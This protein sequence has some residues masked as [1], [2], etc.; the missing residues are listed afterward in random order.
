MTAPLSV[1]IAD[2][3]KTF[4]KRWPMKWIDGW[5]PIILDRSVLPH[6][7][8]LV[9]KRNGEFCV[10]F[11]FEP[12]LIAEVCYHGYMPMGETFRAKPLLLI[13]SHEHRCLLNLPQ[14]HI[15]RKLK[16]YARGLTF[17]INRNFSECLN[18][19]AAHHDQSWLIEPLRAAF[20]HLHYHPI[21]GVAFHSIEIYDG[22]HLVAGE[23]GY[24]TG[25]VYSSLS[26]FHSQNG[27]GSVQLALLGKV[28]ADSQF[29]FWDLGMEIPYKT[30]LGAEVSDR[31]TFLGQWEKHRDRPTPPWSVDSLSP[32]A[33]VEKLRR[34][35]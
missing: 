11:S 33:A 35:S 28:L 10:A 26:G 24:T 17:Q 32:E 3:I 9:E 2:R 16:R 21:A 30:A 12:D 25:A 19:I 15:S 4:F 14:L 7:P 8:Q 13:K 22:D 23:I 5:Y 34:N 18:R 6:V 29:A 31:A 27:A 20:T 1:A